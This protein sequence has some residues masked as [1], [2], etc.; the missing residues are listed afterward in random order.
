MLFKPSDK[1]PEP[2][3]PQ[4][5]L[6]FLLMVSPVFSVWEL[7][8][9][10]PE[11]CPCESSE[12]TW[13]LVMIWL[14]TTWQQQEMCSSVIKKLPKVEF[15]VVS[16]VKDTSITFWFW[17]LQRNVELPSI[18][19]FFLSSC[20]TLVWRLLEQI[21]PCIYSEGIEETE[22][23]SQPIHTEISCWVVWHSFNSRMVS[24]ISI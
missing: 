12:V 9:S 14:F 22:N 15:W 2:L 11:M 23:H 4:T 17:L 7:Q 20:F 18:N 10:L 24:T 6:W 19:Y 13:K 5:Q 21:E 16:L 8:H 3:A 1:D